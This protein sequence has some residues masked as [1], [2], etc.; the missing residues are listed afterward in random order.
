MCYL[1][2]QRVSASEVIIRYYHKN[3]IEKINLNKAC[4]YFILSN[5]VYASYGHELSR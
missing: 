3:K 2:T 1:Y 4:V 5:E